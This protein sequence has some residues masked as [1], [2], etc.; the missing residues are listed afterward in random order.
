VRLAFVG[1]I[2][3]EMGAG[4]CNFQVPA[5][6]RRAQ[7]QNLQ[8]PDVLGGQPLLIVAAITAAL[9][10]ALMLCVAF[11]YASSRMRFVLFD[12]VVASQCRVRDYWRQRGEPAFHYFLWQLVFGVG[13]LVALFV[14][15]VP[16][17]ILAVAA[18]WFENPGAHLVPLVLGGIG[19][20][21]VVIALVIT[22]AVIQVLT[23]DFVVPQMALEGTTVLEGWKRLRAQILA[24]KAGYAAY[25]V[26]KIILTIATSIAVA[27]V[28][29]VV[30]LIVLI[31]VGGVGAIAVLGGQAVGL[32]WTPI[33]VAIAVAL[34]AI[35]VLALLFLFAMIS[36]PLMVFFPAYSY[37]FLA[38]RYPPMRR[39]LG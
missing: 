27:I 7:A 11:L 32:T 35:V 19:V 37:H 12:S 25:I 24:E 1:L 33:T 13:A 34:A 30:A 18:G 10:V 36:V 39:A 17:L 14:A 15:I 26:V 23:K 29:I 5:D 31:P 21:F 20:A 16:P 28:G 38:G 2:A 8:A 9:L 22:L 3:G 6:L 4:S